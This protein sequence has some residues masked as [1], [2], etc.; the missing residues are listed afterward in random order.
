MKRKSAIMQMYYGERGNVERI[1]CSE[2]YYKLLEVVIKSE[3]ELRKELEKIPKLF[4]LYKKT[5]EA[6]DALNDEQL[7]NYYLEAFRFGFLMGL[8][9]A[10]E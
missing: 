5:I 3:E 4:E 2:E 10:Q 1:S 8:D 6:I 7:D 9:V